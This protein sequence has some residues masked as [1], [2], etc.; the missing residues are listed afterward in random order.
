[1]PDSAPL[2]HFGY[3]VWLSLGLILCAAETL[4]PGAFLIWIGAAAVILGTIVFFWPI[5]ITAQLFLFA[6]LVVVLLVIGRR[7]YGSLERRSPPQPFS[8]A[9]GLIGREFFLDRA[10]ERGFGAIRVD[11]SVWRVTGEDM[12]AGAK[13]RVTAVEDGSL[14][15][16]AKA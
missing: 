5:E 4:A 12:G 7:V 2:A 15:R 14:L 6:A 10:I 3:I 9:E 8:R 13:V 1:M 11:D 16:V